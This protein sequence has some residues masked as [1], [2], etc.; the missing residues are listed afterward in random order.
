MNRSIDMAQFP[1]AVD[2]PDDR[3]R[4]DRFVL[5]LLDARRAEL[6][7]CARPSDTLDELDL[8][9]HAGL[10]TSL[11]LTVEGDPIPGVPTIHPVED[12]EIPTWWTAIVE[13]DALPFDT[14]RV[15]LRAARFHDGEALDLHAP[16]QVAQLLF[17]LR[18][19][20]WTPDP[21]ALALH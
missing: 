10:A 16:D 11:P 9:G 20:T 13:I 12:D 8:F 7:V 19:A 3:V 1:A 2:A 4:I 14:R 18:R 5:R 6:R 21:S 17:E 15:L